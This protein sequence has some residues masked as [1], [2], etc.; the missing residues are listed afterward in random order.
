MKR[1]TL[2]TLVVLALLGVMAL[3]RPGWTRP[4]GH[5]TAELPDAAGIRPGDDVRVAGIRV[6]HV[7]GLAARGDRVHVDF[8]LDQDVPVTRDTGTEV[9]L[10]SLLGERYLSLTPG[11]AKR[12]GGGTLPLANAHGSYTI[13]RFWLENGHTLDKLDLTTLSRAVSVLSQDLNGSPRTNRAALDGLASVAGMVAKRDQQISRLLASTRAVTDEVVAQRRQLVGLMRNADQVFTMVEER[14]AAI[15][16][17]LRDSR[18]LVLD[19]TT[20]AKANAAPAERALRRLRTILQVLVRQRDELARTLEVADPAMRLYVN[21]AGDGPWLG[22][23]APYFVLPDSFWCGARK[24][25][26]C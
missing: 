8:T 25:I 12:L 19:L 9:K 22:V 4:A 1:S 13:E 6:G 7:T 26:G 16:A 20:M 5:Y 24:D 17:L 11:V 10:A 3:T 23:N 15:D 18:S 2:I 14:K 21:S